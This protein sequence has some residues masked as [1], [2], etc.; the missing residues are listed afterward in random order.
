MYAHTNRVLYVVLLMYFFFL[1][2]VFVHEVVAWST[3]GV[4]Y[5]AALAV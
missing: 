1:L 2:H 4:K 3:E 5:R